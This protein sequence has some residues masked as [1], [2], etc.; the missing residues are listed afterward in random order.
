[1]EEDIKKEMWFYKEHEKISK[2]YAKIYTIIF[3]FTLPILWIIA[4]F[5]VSNQIIKS[6]YLQN[7]SI[8]PDKDINQIQKEIL[9]RDFKNNINQS[10]DNKDM[11]ILIIQW[12]LYTKWDFI[13]SK[14]N[15]IDYKWYIMPKLFTIEKNI[16]ISQISYFDSDSYDINKL[17]EFITNI[18]Y[19]NKSNLNIAIEENKKLNLNE[20]IEKTFNLSCL[21]QNKI[22]DK[23]CNYYINEFLKYFFV[24][25]LNTDI[26][27]LKN[28]DKKISTTA[29]YKEFCQWIKNYVMYSNNANDDLKEIIW[30]CWSIIAT[31]EFTKIKNFI[32][33]QKELNEWYIKDKDYSDKELNSYK[34]LS[35]QQILYNDVI[36]QKV[37][38]IRLSNYISFLKNI[39]KKDSIEQFYKEET[40]RFNNYFLI[41]NLENSKEANWFSITKDLY[42]INKWES[43]FWIPGLI[44]QIK[45][46]NLETYQKDTT[47]QT[48][49]ITNDIS[50]NQNALTET[51][52]QELLNISFFTITDNKIIWKDTII[53]TWYF[54]ITNKDI[55]TNLLLERYQNNLI[56]KSVNLQKYSSLSKVIN[57]LIQ[58]DNRWINKMY[59]YI[60][61]NIDTYWVED[62]GTIITNIWFCDILKTKISYNIIECS[63]QNVLIDKDWINYRIFIDNQKAYDVNISDKTIETTIKTQLQKSWYNDMGLIETIQGILNYKTQIQEVITWNQ[64]SI[65][66]TEIFQKYLW[67]VPNDVV[68]SKWSL[69]LNFQLQK[70]NFIAEFS[71]TDKVIK[72]LY[73]QDII[74]NWKP[75][76]IKQ[77]SL[78][79]DD[80]N[81]TE[82]NQF[83][84]NPINYIQNLDS[85]AYINYQNKFGK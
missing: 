80:K 40:Y 43:V 52:L 67:I 48:H 37:D 26:Q 49:N 83:L 27:W 79:L 12:K 82:I 18:I 34:L 59:Q 61:D 66:I 19:A 78:L 54:H 41:K 32:E 69:F 6:N 1:M 76:N 71:M 33:I 45:N 53:M 5:F 51:L 15:L 16:P 70:I 30:N 7:I 21:S 42:S 62:T 60:I 24:Y 11:K 85:F 10:I 64:N 9:V 55:K 44:T 3:K 77:F 4:S 74:T 39:I 46:K 14:D 25:N 57:N 81:K 75:L 35:F 50:W 63:D 28:I 23:M 31:D 29:K 22:I 65:L 8:F 13:Y 36:S 72:A 68:E 17:E 84:I 73:F 47:I 56:I 38:T 2:I 58:T 20:N